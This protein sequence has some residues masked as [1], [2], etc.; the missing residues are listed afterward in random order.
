MDRYR[1][2]L[3]YFFLVLTLSPWTI[4][5]V[6]PQEARTKEQVIAKFSGRIPQEWGEVVKGVKTRLNTDQKVLALTFDACGGPIGSD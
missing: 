2:T 1:T 5:S 3:T 6:R 4:E